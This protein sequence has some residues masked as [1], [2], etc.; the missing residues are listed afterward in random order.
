[1]KIANNSRIHKLIVVGDSNVVISQMVLNSTPVDYL[2]A[3][4]INQARQEVNKI[5]SIKLF[6]VLRENNYLVDGFTNQATTLK[7]GDIIINDK[8]YNHLIL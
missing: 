2:L 7:S 3:S 4:M 1:M 5:P 8:V 6:H